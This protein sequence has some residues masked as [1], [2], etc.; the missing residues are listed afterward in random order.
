M[1]R[2][3]LALALLAGPALAQQPPLTPE[4]QIIKAQAEFIASRPD[5][6]QA[7]ALLRAADAALTPKPPA[8]QAPPAP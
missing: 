1:I 2:F 3:A 7:L 8:P 5:I 4:Q 6:A